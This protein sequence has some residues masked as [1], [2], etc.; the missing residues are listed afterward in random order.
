M[1]TA[2]KE[3]K[4]KISISEKLAIEI[5]LILK[6]KSSISLKFLKSNIDN[7]GIE[8]NSIYIKDAINTA[9]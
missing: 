2:S 7:K 8:I 9:T 5:E 4:K 3:N 6:I 1:V